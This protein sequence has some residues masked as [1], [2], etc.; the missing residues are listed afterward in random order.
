MNN[1]GAPLVGALIRFG[2][3]ANNLSAIKNSAL[4]LLARREHSQQELRAKLLVREFAREEIEQVLQILKK[5]NLQSDARFAES[6]ARMRINRGYGP[7]RISQELQQRGINNDLIAENLA[8]DKEFWLEKMNEVK[9]K[10]FGSKIPKDFV[11]KAKQLRF[12]QYRGFV[13]QSRG[14]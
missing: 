7:L 8:Q 5:E 1:V 11:E 6:Y 3:M 12:L 9:H 2:T 13:V 10:K 14:L 4:N